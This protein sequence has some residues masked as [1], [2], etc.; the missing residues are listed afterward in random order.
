MDLASEKGASNWLHHY[1]SVWI[2]PVS[3]VPSRILSRLGMD[4]CHQALP[5][6]S[7]GS[8]FTVEHVLS[9]PRGRFPMVHHNE[10][11]DVTANYLQKYAMMFW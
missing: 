1:R 8:I 7:C 9:C 5:A 11:R 3:K 10:I 2:L 4:S 6:L